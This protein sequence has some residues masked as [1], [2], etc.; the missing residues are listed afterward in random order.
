MMSMLMSATAMAQYAPE[1]QFAASPPP[2]VEL[3]L[4]AVQSESRGITMIAL[5]VAA[6]AGSQFV[7]KDKDRKVLAGAGAGLAV[8]GL[9]NYTIGMEK[10]KKALKGKL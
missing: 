6:V 5:G 3:H 10:R 2:D 9:V 4:Q 7:T 8:I 1:P